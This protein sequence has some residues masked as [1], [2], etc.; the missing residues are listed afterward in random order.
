MG[1]LSSAILVTAPVQVLHQ[2]FAVGSRVLEAKTLG[3]SDPDGRDYDNKDLMTAT[4]ITAEP[5]IS[6]ALGATFLPAQ[7][8]GPAVAL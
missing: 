2:A 5:M 6:E 8:P 4:P 1:L 7:C 3:Y